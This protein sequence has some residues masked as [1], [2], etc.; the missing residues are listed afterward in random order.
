[1]Y[2]HLFSCFLTLQKYK[3]ICRTCSYK[4]TL[5]A[6]TRAVFKCVHSQLRAV[7]VMTGKHI[8]LAFYDHVM[9]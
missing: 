9:I 2:K 5:I 4:N 3:S 1:M 7:F 8:A 6:P